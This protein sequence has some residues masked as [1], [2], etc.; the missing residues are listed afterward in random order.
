MILIL[1]ADSAA[2]LV[3]STIGSHEWYEPS[4]RTSG[5]SGRRIALLSAAAEPAR[6]AY[7]ESIETRAV[8][9]EVV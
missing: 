7:S 2:V 5:F 4:R 6:S 3:P 1:D 9:G 8:T